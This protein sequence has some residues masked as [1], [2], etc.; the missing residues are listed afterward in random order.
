VQDRTSIVRQ[1]EDDGQQTIRVVHPEAYAVRDTQFTVHK[2]EGTIRI[3]SFG[4]SASAGWPHPSS[5]I[6]TEYLERALAAQLSD[7]RVE[8]INLAAH[9]FA[10]YRVRMIFD[11]VIGYDP[12]LV[13]IYSGN[14]DFLE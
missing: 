6:Y 7:R 5:E 8:V 14:N 13:I 4:G 12:D 1:V 2:P 9:A 11:D 3:F 10:S